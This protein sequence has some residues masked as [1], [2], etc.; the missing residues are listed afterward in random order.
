MRLIHLICVVSLSLPLSVFSQG[1]PYNF[2][3]LDIYSGLSHNQ[4]N[5]ILKDGNGFLW[6]GT[7]SGLNRYDGYSCK[8]FRN[9]HN[10]STSLFDDHVLSLYELPDGKMW[11]KTREG[12]CIYNLRTEKF[13]AAHRTYLQSLGLP[14]GTI[15]HIEKGNDGR[16]WF[17]Y[18][19]LD[20]HLYAGADKKV[21]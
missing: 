9:K 3:K 7:L 21:K 10:D 20:L 19:S 6:F 11:V 15:S 5:T 1:D 12:P 14:A 18:D 2:S 16:Y 4:V 8:I 13:D 17:L